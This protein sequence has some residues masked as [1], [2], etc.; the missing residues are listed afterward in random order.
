MATNDYHF[1][2]HWHLPNTTVEEITEIL[3]NGPDL[4]RWWPSVYLRV[5][6]L[7]PGDSQAGLGKVLDLYTKGWLPYTLRWQFRITENVSPHGFSLEAWGDF[8]GRGIWT[9]EQEGEAVNVTYDWKIRAGKPLLRNL[10]FLLKPVFSANHQWAMRMGERSLLL[11]L[12][13]RHAKSSAERAI[14]PAAPQAT[15]ISPTPIL[16]FLAAGVVLVWALKRNQ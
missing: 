7:E 16:L 11:E 13:R 10:S 14:I 12:A 4:A 6:E 8:I 1:I 5:T 15:K 9:F 3:G 2:T